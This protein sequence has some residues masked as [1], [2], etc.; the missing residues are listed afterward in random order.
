M[1]ATARTL[2][3][4]EMQLRDRRSRLMRELRAEAAAQAGLAPAEEPD[5]IDRSAEEQEIARVGRLSELERGA[6][7]RIDGALERIR[8]G[9]YGCCVACG[10]RIEE[11]RLRKLPETPMCLSCAVSRAS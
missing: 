5:W 11:M 1:T 10:G 4:I 7:A 6:V 3:K 9:T 2:G 8:R